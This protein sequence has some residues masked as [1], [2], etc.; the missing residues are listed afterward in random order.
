VFSDLSTFLI[1]RVTKFLSFDLSQMFFLFST[2]LKLAKLIWRTHKINLEG[3]D[4][5]L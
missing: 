5:F 3:G 2:K 4:V 1:D